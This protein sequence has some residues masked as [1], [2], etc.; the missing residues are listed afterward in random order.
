M[1][2]RPYE[3]AVRAYLADCVRHRAQLDPAY[4]P[5]A[6][7][8]VKMIPHGANPEAAEQIRQAFTVL[9]S[10]VI[11]HDPRPGGPALVTLTDLP[12]LLTQ[13]ATGPDPAP[14]AAPAH[15]RARR[16]LVTGSRTW[17]DQA[18]IAGALREQW[19]AGTVLVCGTCPRGADAIAERLWTTWGGPV[20]RHPANWGTGRGA[21]LARNAAMVAAGADVC[22]AFIRDNSPGASHAAQL[23]GLVGIP[24]RRY[25]HPEQGK[26]E[27]APAGLTIEAAALRYMGNGWPVFVLGRSKR[28]VANCAACRAAGAGHD[29]AGCT[30][31]T[32]HGFYAAT[33]DPDRLAAML[34]KVPGG[35]LAIRTGRVSGLCVVDIDP[36]NGGQLDKALMTPTATVATGGAA[37]TCTTATPA[38]PPSRPCPAQPRWTSKATAGTSP[39]RPRFTRAPAAATGGRAAEP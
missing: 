18:V 31:L 38:A 19:A 23:A 24:V 6:A 3:A 34:V 2:P 14:V 26:S 9:T 10:P 4:H 12:A 15:P 17:T 37:G 27:K 22:L 16:V 29:K 28:P 39:P 30:C 35:L 5:T 11:V 25:N 33:L 1:T 8:A 32:C 21:G 20:E 7:G 36:R 13:H